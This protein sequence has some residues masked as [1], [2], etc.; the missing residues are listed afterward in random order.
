MY[1]YQLKESGRGGGRWDVFLRAGVREEH[2]LKNYVD[3][4]SFVCFPLRLVC[5]KYFLY[6]FI[7]P[8]AD[9]GLLA[10]VLGW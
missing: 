2:G 4:K 9:I 3:T 8:P 1:V 7:R 6:F 10:V 5:R